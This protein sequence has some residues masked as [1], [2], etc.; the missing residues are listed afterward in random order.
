MTIKTWAL[1]G[2][3]VMLACAKPASA[4][5][6]YD[7]CTGFITSLPAVI[8]TQ[9]T[10]CLKQDL[11]TAVTTG[12]A[13]TIN[14]NNVT[15]DCNDFKLGGL[16]AGAGTQTI[17]IHALNRLNATV[18]RCNIRGFYVG[19]LFAGTGGGHAIED[20]RL[21]GNTSSG[22]V[23]QGD[24]SV[25]RRNRVFDTGGSTLGGD[26]TGIY[27]DKS[28][29]V[30]DNTVSGAT[31]AAST[32]GWGIGITANNDFDGSIVGNRVRG[33]VPG[34]TG[35]TFGLIATSSNRLEVRDNAFVGDGSVNSA[36]VK[37]DAA[38]G[39]VHNNTINLFETAIVNCNDDGGNI[40][41]P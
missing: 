39:N 21:D 1:L 24:G 18:R 17:G 9:G 3:L 2:L 4:A 15:I 23:V 7:N 35:T 12:N 34:G 41:H 20:N 27:A 37:C 28:V 10:W 25:V 22:I 32:N 30:I 36:G 38:N 11:S 40:V 19:L 29:D 16:S 31:G 33:L 5:Q 26:G 6:S 13:I 14:T 8:S